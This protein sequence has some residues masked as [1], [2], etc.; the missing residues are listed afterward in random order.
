M[1][2][3]QP[4]TTETANAA[5]RAVLELVPPLKLF[6]TMSYA[7]EALQGF[8]G[9]GAALLFKTKLDPVWREIVILVVAHARGNDYEITEHERIAREVGCPLEKVEALRATGSPWDS[10]P[11]S[12]E[13]S[14]LARF[15]IEMVQQQ[16]PTD[17]TYSAVA[18]LLGPQEL[19]ELVMCIAYYYA[20]AMFLD[21]FA[22]EPEAV[23]FDDGVKVADY[24]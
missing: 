20:A 19:V 23:G 11:F 9:H 12:R 15:A 4:L 13:E 7:P 6:R 3:L 21:A 22:I 10:A 14:A 8:A 16:A 1:K 24:S 17:E 2:R 18:A 5:Q